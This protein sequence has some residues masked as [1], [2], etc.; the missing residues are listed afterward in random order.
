MRNQIH[1]ISDKKSLEMMTMVDEAVVQPFRISD[2]TFLGGRGEM[3]LASVS[4]R[5]PMPTDLVPGNSAHF[6]FV[7]T[8][9]AY[10][11]KPPAS[12]YPPLYIMV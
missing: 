3:G 11:G 8:T 5:G 10:E 1:G 6:F 12:Q 4:R 7:F 2:Y 9:K